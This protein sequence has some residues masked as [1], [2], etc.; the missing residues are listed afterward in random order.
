MFQ[1]VQASPP[2][3]TAVVLDL[4]NLEERVNGF[5]GNVK[6][7]FSDMLQIEAARNTLGVMLLCTLELLE[8][9]SA[10]E[11]IVNISQQIKDNL[12][13]GDKGAMSLKYMQDGVIDLLTH[14]VSEETLKALLNSASR[15]IR[16]PDTPIVLDQVFDLIIEVS[17]IDNAPDIITTTEA[18]IRTIA[19]REDPKEYVMR[20]FSNLKY[21]MM[22]GKRDKVMHFVAG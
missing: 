10:S 20:G 3:P 19:R 6:K 2:E 12:I 18:G 5:M 8:D 16:S 14:E 1:S 21:F 9:Q 13:D 17:K 4:D 15:L 11:I 22:T 7:F